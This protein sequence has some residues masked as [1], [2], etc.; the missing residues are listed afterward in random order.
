MSFQSSREVPLAQLDKLVADVQGIAL[1]DAD[2]LAEVQSK[3]SAAKL[4]IEGAYKK[5]DDQIEASDLQHY[6]RFG[7]VLDLEEEVKALKAERESWHEEL[8]SREHIRLVNKYF[9]LFRAEKKYSLKEFEE[10]LVV[11]AVTQYDKMKILFAQTVGLTKM[12]STEAAPLY[13]IKAFVDAGGIVNGEEYQ[14]SPLWFAIHQ[15]RA[16]LVQY[17][18]QSGAPFPDLEKFPLDKE[19]EDFLRQQYE[20]YTNSIT[21]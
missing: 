13:R 5:M 20:E 2:L 21:K 7:Q 10:M 12:V 17:L 19:S 9:A 14:A 3:I 1:K 11:E 8:S 4:C 6:R 15:K 18:F 16:A